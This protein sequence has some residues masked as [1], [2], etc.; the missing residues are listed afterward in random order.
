L[1]GHP[2]VV[3]LN[4]FDP[5]EELHVRNRRWLAERD[6]LFVTVRAHELAEALLSSD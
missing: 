2:L 4:H 5:G 1:S 6:G 3:Y